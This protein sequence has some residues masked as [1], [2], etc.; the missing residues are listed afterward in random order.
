MALTRLIAGDW[1]EQETAVVLDL[2]VRQV[3]RLKKDYQTEGIRALIHGNRGS[4]PWNRMDDRVRSQVLELATT[5]YAGVND[6]HLSEL[7]DE[8]EGIHRSRSSVRRVLRKGGI[9][10]PRKRRSPKHRSRRERMAQEGMLLQID[11][12]RHDWLEGRGPYLTLIGGI[13]DA[14][15]KTP[16]AVFRLQ[17]DAQGY[18]LLIEHLVQQ[19]GIPLAIY[20]DRHGIFEPTKGAKLTLEEQFATKREPTQFGRLLEELEITSIAARSPQA[21][22][23]IERLWGTFQDRLVTELRLQ[24]AATIEEA[25][26]V[27]WDFL[28]K[29]NSR[30][31][32]PAATEGTAYRALAPTPPIEL[33]FCFKYVRTVAADNTVQLGEHRLQLLPGRN[34]I[35]F[36]RCQVEVHERIDGGLAVYYQGE[37][38]ASQAAPAEAP[39]LRAR[40]Y[41]RPP[42]G[43]S[44]QALHQRVRVAHQL[45]AAIENGRPTRDH[46]WKKGLKNQQ[47]K[48]A[49]Q[50]IGQNR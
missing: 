35:S 2:S 22:G 10:S 46:P 30:F 48:I 18:F 5:K 17:E 15:G 19:E 42:L 47:D 9:A 3:R 37:L 26:Q 33:L 43:E 31:S 36:V 24:K 25:N 12:S 39:K 13:D 14:T 16:Y 27:L 29:Y 21:K 8:R 23:R 38:V 7:L 45:P 34:R 20:R 6:Q 1:T 44:A 28:P 32:V 41:S 4:I 50:L 11:G 49:E 40:Q